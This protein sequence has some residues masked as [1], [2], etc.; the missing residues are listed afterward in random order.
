MKKPTSIN[1]GIGVTGLVPSGAGGRERYQRRCHR[2]KPVQVLVT[3]QRKRE[4]DQAGDRHVTASGVLENHQRL[5]FTASSNCRAS[6]NSGREGDTVAM[7]DRV[8]WR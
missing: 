5:V 7:Y 1:S 6:C 4:S 2:Q 3:A 8:A